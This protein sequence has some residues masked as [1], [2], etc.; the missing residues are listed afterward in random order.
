[1]RPIGPPPVHLQLLEFTWPLLAAEFAMHPPP[2]GFLPQ[3]DGA[4]VLVLPGFTTDDGATAVLRRVVS[5]HGFWV[6]PWSLGRNIGPT[7]QIVDGMRS[8]LLEIAS[9]HGRPVSLVGVSLGGVY[10]RALAREFPRQVSQIV[11][12]GSPY[13]LLSTDRTTV[14]AIWDYL[15][16]YHEDDLS[17]F[18]AHEDAR[19]PLSVPA[20][21]IYSRSD[22]IVPWEASIDRTGLDAPNPSAENIE[23]YGTHVG[24]CVNP[25]AIY[26]LIDRLVK[27]GLPWRPFQPPPVI[28]SWYPTPAIAPRQRS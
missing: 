20:T 12:L 4:P 9:L 11:S 24:M 25:A 16:P 28:R 3:G 13:R 18:D 8:L 19:D 26:A 5:D 15:K 6:A 1:M 2:I 22:G 27:V 10:A 17:L 7:R 23:V 14:H 21:S